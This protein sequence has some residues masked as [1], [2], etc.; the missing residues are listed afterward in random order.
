MPRGVSTSAELKP[1]PTSV[2][3][4]MCVNAYSTTDIVAASSI[5]P[6]WAPVGGVPSIS[7]TCS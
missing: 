2:L 4:T 7:G 3:A 1:N 5:I 6:L